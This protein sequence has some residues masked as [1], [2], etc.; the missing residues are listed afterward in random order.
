MEIAH[1]VKMITFGH[2]FIKNY[3]QK[4]KDDEK[5]NI[6]SLCHNYLWRFLPSQKTH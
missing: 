3:C 2:H 6:L 4:P 5:A 1:F